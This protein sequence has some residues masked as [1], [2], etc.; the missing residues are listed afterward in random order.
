MRTTILLL[1]V[2]EAPMLGARCP[3]RSGRRS[4]RRGRCRRRQRLHGRHGRSSPRSPTA[5]GACALAPA[6][7]LRGGDQRGHRADRR[8][9]GAA[10]ERRLLPATRVPGRGVA[11]AG[12]AASRLGGARSCCGG[13]PGA[14]RAARAEID[15]AGMFIDRRRKNGLVGHGRPGARFAAPAPAFGA[16][17]AAALYRRETLAD[18]ALDNREVLDEDLAL[19]ASDADLAWR[20]QLL[21]WRVRVRARGGRRARAHL[22]PEQPARR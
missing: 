21:G 10:T 4:P 12:R 17:G 16:D 18:C 8:R 5:R 19:W 15:A 13:G 1:S 22:Q 9:G 6:P 11:A 14:G 20:A 3:P 2:D 7:Q